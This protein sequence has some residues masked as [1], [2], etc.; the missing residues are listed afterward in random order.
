MRFLSER[1]ELVLRTIIDEYIDTNEPVGSRNVSKVGPLKMSPATIRNI[2]SDLVDKGFIVQPHTSAGR[3]PT[4]EGYRYYIDKLVSTQIGS[5]DL[6]KNIQNEMTFDPVNVMNLFRVF[7][8]KLGDMTNAVGFIVSPKL[9]SMYMKHIEFIRLNR[10]TVLAVLVARSGIV[11]NILLNVGPDFSDEDLVRMGNYLNSNF[12]E[13]SLAEIRSNLFRK[14]RQEHGEIRTLLEKTRKVGEALFDS[15]AFEEEFIFEG[16]GNIVDTPE[17]RNSGK[18]KEVLSAFEEKRRICDILDNCMT[19]NS[20]QIFVGSEIGLKDIE[21]LGM[22]IKPYQR[23]GNI[24]GT[25]GV[26]GPKRMKYPKVVSIVDYSS[27]IISRMLNEYY[28]G[29]DDK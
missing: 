15:P 3:V 26:I 29:D 4:D 12:Q 1:E 14:M 25:L 5:E 2:M 18:L 9:S 16:T 11:R 19:S 8:K 6:I 23:G 28:G 10:D 7:S 24:I 27:R 22:V 20:V 21:E 17:L 13:S